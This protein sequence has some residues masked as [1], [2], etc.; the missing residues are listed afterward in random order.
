MLQQTTD[1]RS[2]MK[3][4]APTSPCVVVGRWRV[5]FGCHGVLR[6]GNLRVCNG[7]PIASLPPFG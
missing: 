1:P 7:T 5:E 6:R 2:M 4:T 3:N